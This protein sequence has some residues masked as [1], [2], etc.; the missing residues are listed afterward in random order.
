MEKIVNKEVKIQ[1]QNTK[2]KKT[3]KQVNKNLQ[4]TLRE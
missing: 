2:M 1:Q 4:T 3:G